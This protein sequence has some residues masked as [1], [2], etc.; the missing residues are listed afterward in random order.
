MCGAVFFRVGAVF[1]LV[2]RLENKRLP[3]QDK[4]NRPRTKEPV[5]E[6]ETKSGARHLEKFHYLLWN[7]F[8]KIIFET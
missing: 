8:L 5:E 7:K 1:G 4:R 6:P 3:P 2:G